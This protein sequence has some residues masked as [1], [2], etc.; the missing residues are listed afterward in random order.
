[1]FIAYGALKRDLVYDGG[2]L[3]ALGHWQ[4]ILTMERTPSTFCTGLYPSPYA[5][6]S[7]LSAQ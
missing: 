3:W 6:C 7:L 1:M 2:T 5:G 4:G